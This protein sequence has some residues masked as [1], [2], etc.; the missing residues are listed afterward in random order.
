ME[1]ANILVTIYFPRENL[2]T[3]CVFFF[4]S[5]FGFFDFGGFPVNLGLVV[6]IFGAVVVLVVVL[7]VVVEVVVDVV[8]VVVLVVVVLVVVVLGFL[9]VNTTD[10]SARSIL[11]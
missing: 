8:V 6:V 5:R 4:F 1:P 2:S 10:Q 3:V 11:Y 9:L 7:V